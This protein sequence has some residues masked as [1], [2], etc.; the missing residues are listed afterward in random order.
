MHVHIARSLFIVIV[1]VF[2]C[3]CG[4]TTQ[5]S[6][7]EQLLLSSAVDRAVQ[8]I[9][10]S[11][12][13]DRKVYLDTKYFDHIQPA[14]FVN[15]KYIASA[16]RQQMV[17]ANCR[18]MDKIEEAEIVVEPRVG[19]LGADGHEVTYGL[20]QSNAIGSAASLLSNVPSV[21]ILPDL[22]VGRSDAQS[23]IARLAVFAYYRDSR[24][25]IW[26]SGIAKGRSD[27]RSTWILGAGPFQRGSIYDGTR[28]AGRR[29]KDENELANER[30]N[31]VAIDY[32]D[33]YRFPN[34]PLLRTA[35]ESNAINDETSQR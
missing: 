14:S 24:E 22:S 21:P 15:A 35:S 13:S 11:V 18:L 12:L 29:I 4:T 33:E 8:Q 25:P 5:R 9:D 30:K 26:Q 27:S 31:R 28:F 16:I 19:A 7:T 23:A 1:A 10:F 17:A 32:Q 2:C 34:N 20:P 3:S 6:G